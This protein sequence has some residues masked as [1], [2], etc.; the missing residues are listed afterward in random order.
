L[1]CSQETGILEIRDTFSGKKYATWRLESNS[2]FAIEFIHSVNK[3]P[4]RETFYVNN[5]KIYLQNVRFYSY[6]AGIQ[7]DLYEEQ[8][9]SYDNDALVVSGF[10]RSY[11]ELNYIVS[12]HILIINNNVICLQ[13]ITGKSD[14]E[15]TSITIQYR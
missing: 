14:K 8:Q 15:S 6:G 11:K 10:N 12:D 4:V 9:L 1:S 13:E 2:K 7:S 5:E 3:S